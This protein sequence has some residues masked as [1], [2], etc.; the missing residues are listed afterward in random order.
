[1]MLKEHFNKISIHFINVA[2]YITCCKTFQEMYSFKN[3]YRINFHCTI[4]ALDNTE[5]ILSRE[6]D[7]R[8]SAR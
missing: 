4:T 2:K 5:E 7:G 8:A 6:K 3:Y 1:M